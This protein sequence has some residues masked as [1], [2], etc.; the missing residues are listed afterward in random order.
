[1][2][3]LVPNYYRKYAS[4]GSALQPVKYN[5]YSIYEGQ[6]YPTPSVNGKSGNVSLGLGNNLE[7]KVRSKDDTTGQGKKVTILENL[8]FATSY[9]PFATTNKWAAVTMT[10]RSTLFKRNLQ[11]QFRS[12]F[13]PYAIDS[14]WKNHQHL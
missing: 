5:D 14:F 11:L 1:M 13:D 9:R 8:D 12:T 4:Q 3:K 6:L 2:K 10:G 7:M